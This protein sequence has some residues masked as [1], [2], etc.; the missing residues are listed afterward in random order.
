MVVL[1]RVVVLSAL[2]EVVV[3]VVVLVERTHLVVERATVGDE[4]GVVLS[5]MVAP[6]LVLGAVLRQRNVCVVLPR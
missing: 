6:R 5:Q 2:L 1:S 4:L 3:V